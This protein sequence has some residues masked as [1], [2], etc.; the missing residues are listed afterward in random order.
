MDSSTPHVTMTT[1]C[2]SDIFLGGSC[3]N[4]KWRDDIVIPLLRFVVFTTLPLISQI[5]NSTINLVTSCHTH[6]V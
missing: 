6:I 4:S 1:V 2:H 5:N 3:G